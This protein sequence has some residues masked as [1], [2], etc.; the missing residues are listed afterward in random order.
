MCCWCCPCPLT[1]VLQPEGVL[2]V[3]RHHLD[4][5]GACWVH[6]A[7]A[8]HVFFACLYWIIYFSGELLLWKLQF[9]KS[10]DKEQVEK[11]SGQGRQLVSHQTAWMIAVPLTVSRPWGWVYKQGRTEHWSTLFRA[12]VNI[13]YD[14]ES[15]EFTGYK[16]WKCIVVH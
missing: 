11:G 15:L 13:S 6:A 9:R 3:L 4:S 2:G 7:H 5:A 10:G 14:S 1:R 12:S 8:F 16:N